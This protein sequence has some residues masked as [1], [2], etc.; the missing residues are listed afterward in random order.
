[1]PKTP[2][3]PLTERGFVWANQVL[4]GRIPSCEF[5]KLAVQRFQRDIGRTK[6]QY[7]FDPAES[8]RWLAFLSRLPHVKGA[9]RRRRELFDPAGYQCFCTMNV[10]GWRD[11][12]TGMRR[13]RHGYVEV[14]RKNGKSFWAA[15]IGLGHLCIDDEPGA[16]V[17]CG[18]TT[19]KQAWEVFRPAR[20]ICARSPELKNEYGIEV[21]AKSLWILEE[22]ARFEPLIGNPGDGPGP[23]CAIVDEYHEHKSS[24][25]LETMTTGMG[26]RE[27]PVLWVITTAG[28]DFGGPCREMRDDVIRVINGTVDDET[29]FGIIF[30]LDEGDPWDTEDALRKANPNYGVSVNANYLTSELGK[31][32]RSASKQ[33]SFKTKHLDLW[34]GAK[35]SWMNMLAFQACKRPRLKMAKFKGSRAWVGIDLASRIDVASVAILIPQRERIYAFYRHYLP[36]DT[37]YEETKND[38]YKGWAETGSLITTPGNII[39][40]DLIE[41]DLKDLAAELEI[42]E[43]AYDPFQAT[44]FSTRMTAEGFEMVEVRPTV[45]N[46]SEPMKDLEALI[47]AKKFLFD[48]DPVLTWMMGNVTAQLDKK[49]NI[50]PNK[51]REANKIDGVVATIMALNRW[52]AVK[53]DEMPDDYELTVV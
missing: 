28:S 8:E 31:A 11:K 33:N 43:V 7:Q 47:L 24:D 45:L 16:E 18:A 29:V 39:D 32:R 48:G 26:A 30:T 17:Y 15:G 20:T 25:L 50:Y 6:W 21:N 37:V 40:Y 46:F 3:F 14:P 4:T 2:A 41:D 52:I 5:V 27:Q 44:Q 35:T 1:M 42:V 23:S 12:K 51:E 34:V 38:R 10:Y 49:D 22:G 53:D 9:W 36:E 19:E 13:F